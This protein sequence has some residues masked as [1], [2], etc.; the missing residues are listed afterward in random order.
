MLQSL[1][2]AHKARKRFG[3]NFLQDPVVIHRIIQTIGPKKNDHMVEIGPGQGAL[4]EPLVDACKNLDVIELD[5]DLVPRLKVQFALSEGF[6]IH[7]GDALTFDY[8]MLQ[9]D[10]KL[11]RLAGNLPYNISTPL[12][13]YLLSYS[14]LIQDMHFMLQKEVVDRLTAKPGE[15]NYGRLSVMTQYHCTT[16]N[17]LYVAPSAF[18]PP[19]KVDSAIVRLVPFKELPFVCEDYEMLK[20]IVRQ[21][22]GFRRKTLRNCL[23]DVISDNQLEKLSIDPQLRPENIKLEQYISIADFITKR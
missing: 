17:L 1:S 13:F 20:K 15:K 10:G 19:P 23:K 12:I 21:A 18:Y 11:L 7:Q 22:F 16:E 5:R 6:R 2:G 14:D 4:T 9:K 8:S 3:Q